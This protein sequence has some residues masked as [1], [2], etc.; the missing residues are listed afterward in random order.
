MKR[1]LGLSAL[2]VISV[3]LGLSSLTLA[4]FPNAKATPDRWWEQVVPLFPHTSG[5]RWIYVLSGKQYV[6]GRELDAAVKGWKLPPP[7]L[8]Q[9][10]LLVE[11]TH[12]AAVANESPDIMPV[13]YYLRE[14]SLVRKTSSI[15]GNSQR[16]RVTSTGNLGETVV[17]L[18]PLWQQ[19]EG[20]D[21]KPVAEEHWGRAAQLASAYHV[22]PE[23]RATVTVEA[24]KYR[25]CV[26]VR[27]TVNRGD[28]SG[29]RYQEWYAPGVGLVQTTTTEL[30]SGEI[31]FHKE[32][33]SFRSGLP[34]GHTNA[35]LDR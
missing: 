1:L 16:S 31:L 30:Q 7:H 20:T 25:D 26:P 21:W 34:K 11:E 32:L 15:Y 29:Y 35:P 24:G 19:G 2:V 33:V 3:F 17:P 5:N 10:A 8:K 14:G 28:G 23:K 9:E 6:N 27:G 13:L 12:P 4:E 18:L 22:H